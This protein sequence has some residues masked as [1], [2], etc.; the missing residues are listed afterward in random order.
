[1][2]QIIVGLE[3]D[4]RSRRHLYYAIKEL[5]GLLSCGRDNEIMPLMMLRPFRGIRLVAFIYK[6]GEQVQKSHFKDIFA[7]CLDIGT[8]RIS[9]AG[10]FFSFSFFTWWP[11]TAALWFK[12]Q[13]V[14]VLLLTT[15]ADPMVV[16]YFITLQPAAAVCV[17]CFFILIC[18]AT[19]YCFP[20]LL[21]LIR[22]ERV[23]PNNGIMTGTGWFLVLVLSASWPSAK[24][25]EWELLLPQMWPT[26]ECKGLLVGI[27]CPHGLRKGF[28]LVGALT[29]KCFTGLAI[30]DVLNFF[31][32][33]IPFFLSS[34]GGTQRIKNKLL[35]W[36]ACNLRE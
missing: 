6:C 27:K 8:T 21:H 36:F 26:Y 23:P 17:T 7:F 24:A 10:L 15:G 3:I 1:M 25:L 35:P 20:A 13:P 9:A 29:V 34:F 32:S 33:R 30:S 2:P 5:E 4:Q 19:R 11:L 14:G 12:R 28:G 16:H 31:T 22:T 18:S